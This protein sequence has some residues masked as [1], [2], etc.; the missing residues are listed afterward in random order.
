MTENIGD[1]IPPWWTSLV[2][3]KHW[4][5]MNPIVQSF[6]DVDTSNITFY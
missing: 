6:L 2:K 1:I 5:D 3:N 4:I